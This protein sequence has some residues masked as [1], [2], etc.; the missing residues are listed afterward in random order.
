MLLNKKRDMRKHTPF[1]KN[2]SITQL[3]LFELQIHQQ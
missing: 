3:G 2:N 1:K